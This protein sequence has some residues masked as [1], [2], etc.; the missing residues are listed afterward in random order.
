LYGRVSPEESSFLFD[1]ERLDKLHSLH[2]TYRDKCSRC[3]F[4]LLC[5]GGCPM[6]NVWATGFPP[7]PASYRCQVEYQ[8]LPELLTRL[9]RSSKYENII[10]DNVSIC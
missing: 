8:L 3:E 7:K 2:Y 10:L 4:R 1:S 9:A 6:E 5:G